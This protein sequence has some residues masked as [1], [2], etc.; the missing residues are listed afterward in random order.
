MNELIRPPGQALASESHHSQTQT[1]TQSASEEEPAKTNRL[2]RRAT[3]V[4]T[5]RRS[6]SSAA[7]NLVERR[8]V[9]MK[10]AM[11]WGQ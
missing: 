9:S 7:W 11:S 10:R 3:F 8:Y 1:Q 2:M 6:E 4:T 5:L